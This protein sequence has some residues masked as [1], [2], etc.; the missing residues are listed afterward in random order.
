MTNPDLLT[1]LETYLPYVYWFLAIMLFKILACF[2]AYKRGYNEGWSDRQ[3]RHEVQLLQLTRKR[4][5]R[6]AS[7][8]GHQPETGASKEIPSRSR[9][10]APTDTVQI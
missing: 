2:Q 6:K 10:N 9:P 5:E 1:T 3:C 8:C 4:A 7:P